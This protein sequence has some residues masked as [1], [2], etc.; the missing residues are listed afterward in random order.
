MT[1]WD[2]AHTWWSQ[3]HPQRRSKGGAEVA[4]RRV[5]AFSTGWKSLNFIEPPPIESREKK[6]Y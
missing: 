4:E 6:C 1:G 2:F 5:H 3:R